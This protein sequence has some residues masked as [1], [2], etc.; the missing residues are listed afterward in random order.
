MKSPLLWAALAMLAHPPLAEAQRSTLERM[1]QRR[2]LQNG[3]EIVVV[4]NHGV[5]LAT[6]EI[7][8]RNGAF[9]Q[10]PTTEGVAHLYEH[11]F[12]KGSTSYPNPDAFLFRAAELGATFNG[13][14]QEERV[15]YY[16]T[17]PADS[18][19]G[20]ME[21]LAGALRSPTFD[22]QELRKEREVVIGE[23]DRAESSPYFRLNQR[24]DTLLYGAEVGRK[25]TIGR[26]EVILSATPAILREIQR[27]YYVPNNSVL[28]VT[29]DVDPVRTFELAERTFGDW[30]R[31]ADPFVAHPVPPIPE[32]T[33]SKAVI[34][35]E[36]VSDALILVQWQGPSVREDPEATYAADVF[37]DVLNGAG[38]TLQTR[39]VESGLFQS[40]GV[41]YYTL[42]NVGPITI[43][44]VIAPRRLRDG[45]AALQ[46][47]IAQLADSGYYTQAELEPV[48]RQ[49]AVSTMLNL[50][51]ASGFA[52]QLGF[53]WSVVGLDYFM[54]YVDS[55]AAQDVGDLRGYAA[56]YIVG[57][58]YVMGVILSPQDRQA[59]ALEE[60]DLLATP[61]VP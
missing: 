47:E 21:W 39:L 43:A 13:T 44:A 60:R 32:L 41:N 16:V 11:M 6:L 8:V 7:N 33:A 20:G 19:Q 38:S 9:T 49:R 42:S 40:V 53:W 3:M 50:E 27:R 59:L 58:P 36:P 51:R 34:A 17:L 12:F 4:E 31:G 14:T 26:R 55:M 35:E 61:E 10:T 1:I 45:I 24:M 2:T 23:Y 15:N 29:G 57:K 48:K 22:A 25:N 37:S 52:H 56:K 28:I 54:G 30:P 18:I 46:R 5:P